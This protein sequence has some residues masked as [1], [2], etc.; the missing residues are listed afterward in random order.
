MAQGD[1]GRPRSKTDAERLTALAAGVERLWAGRGGVDPPH[2]AGPAPV[3]RR[4]RARPGQ[5]VARRRIGPAARA[6]PRP[7]RCW[8][9]PNSPLGRLRTLMDAWVGLW[10]W[11]L[12]SGQ[13]P[14]TW[15]E[16]LRG[17]GAGP[18]RRAPRPGRP[19]RPVRR[20]GR[21]AGR[22]RARQAGQVTVGQICAPQH[23]WLAVARR[24]R[25]AG[26]RLA[27]GPRVRPGVRRPAGSISRS[28]TR[29]GSARAGR[30]IWS[31]P[32]TTRGGASSTSP[33]PR[34]SRTAEPSTSAE[35]G[36]SGR[37]SG[38]AGQRRRQ[39][40]RVLGSP[41]LRPVLAG[42]QTNLYMVFMDTV[43]R[44]LGERGHGGPAP[45]RKPLHR[46]QG[47]RPPPSHLRPPPPPLAVR[48]RSCKLFED[49]S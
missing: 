2:P 41:V 34:S 49:S 45:P 4:L 36:R 29:R 11:P 5:A 14:P 43:W 9:T 37:L 21:A 20:P 13:R 42:I 27:L 12:D 46:P 35:P 23:P 30:T 31:W 1:A 6:A 8:P 38:R 32:S 48:Q 47:R 25:A 28:G 22:R 39:P 19:A 10:F 33:A 26:G 40:S 7:R 16:W 18:P 44:H 24:R 3:D 17:R 15:G